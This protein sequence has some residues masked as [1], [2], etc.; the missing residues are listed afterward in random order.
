MVND[1]DIFRRFSE[2][3][4]RH[5]GRAVY[6]G[7]M[8]KLQSFFCRPGPKGFDMVINHTSVR[9]VMHHAACAI[10]TQALRNEATLPHGL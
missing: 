1:V 8:L 5:E 3:G 4:F 7:H 2:V 10:P 6:V 9:W